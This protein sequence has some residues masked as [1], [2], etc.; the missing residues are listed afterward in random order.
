MNDSLGDMKAHIFKLNIQAA[1]FDRK[2]RH[3][4]LG[5]DRTLIVTTSDPEEVTLN[6]GNGQ[7]E[8]ILKS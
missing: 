3:L 6:L 8:H 7:E 2:I 4:V 1:N 5:L